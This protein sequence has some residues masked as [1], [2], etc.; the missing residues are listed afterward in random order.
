MDKSEHTSEIFYFHPQN[1]GFNPLSIDEVCIIGEFNEWGI[2]REHT[3]LS[4]EN[5]KLT[6]D[7]TN[8]WIGV[9]QVPKGTKPFKFVLNKNTYCPNIGHLYYS[10]VITPQWAKECI[11]YQ[12]IPDRFYGKNNSEIKNHLSWD[13]PPD[14]FNSYGGNFQGIKQKIDYLKI[15]FN[16]LDKVAFYLNPITISTASNHKYWPEDFEKID[17]AFGTADELK[18]LIDLIHN[19]GGKI[20]LD[21]VYNHTGL[22]HYAFLDV[23]K[24]GKKSRYFNWYRGL[25]QTDHDKIRIPVLEKSHDSDYLNITIENDP[26]LPD[27]DENKESF[28]VIWDGKYKFPITNPKQFKNSSI[29]HIIDNQPYYRLTSIHSKPNYNCWFG[30][31][32]IPELNT[33]NEKVKEHLYE[34]SK[35]WVRLGVD[36]FRLD[37]PDMLSGAHEFWKGFRTAVKQEAELCEKNPDELFVLGELWTNGN[38]T[39]SYLLPDENSLPVRFDA[40]MNYPVREGVLNFF[41][42]DILVPTMDEIRS[43]GEFS[44]KETDINIHKNI[45]HLPWGVDRVMVNCFGTHDTRRLKTAI[46]NDKRLKA[47][48]IMQFTL[49]GSP[50]VYY[51]D[52]VG[53]K[54]GKDPLNR[55]AM[56]WSIIENIDQ[57]IDEY[58]IFN[59]YK[60]LIDLRKNS[61]C[62]TNAPMY[63]LLTDDERQIYAFSR[64]LDNNNCIITA[65]SKEGLKSDLNLDIS[66]MPFENKINWVNPLTD[67]EYMA[68]GRSITIETKDFDDIYGVILKAV[69]S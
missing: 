64:F 27:F 24:N 38:I 30:F 35:K 6:K 59:L 11:W 41:S 34:A 20:I 63:T 65:V 18:E 13:A 45:A 69:P 66:G 61:P 28:F 22:N 58:E 37:V 40:V 46:K 43:Q 25:N 26:R 44:V 8:R 50:F 15:F 12:I 10:T 9:F 32:E 5:F 42:G 2:H 68:Y 3:E 47:A 60:K 67:K 49:V 57:H 14:Y 23:L 31:F 51:G 1:Y 19:E 36:G 56:T 62:L 52:E 16:G 55:G 33:K 17:P 21:L 29:D 48:L 53:M 4:I 7:K 39:N 54:G